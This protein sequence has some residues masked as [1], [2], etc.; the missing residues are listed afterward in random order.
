MIE[1]SR[2]QEKIPFVGNVQLNVEVLPEEKKS[3][4]AI[5]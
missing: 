2:V 3:L 4:A 1:T 5:R